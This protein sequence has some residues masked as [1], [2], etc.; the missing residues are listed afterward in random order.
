MAAMA[1]G[2][3]TC[4]SADAIVV[5]SSSSSSAVNVAMCDSC[6]NIVETPPDCSLERNNEIGNCLLTYKSKFGPS[7]M[8]IY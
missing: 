3:D 1:T 2:E 4:S 5:A 7:S 8:R 6:S